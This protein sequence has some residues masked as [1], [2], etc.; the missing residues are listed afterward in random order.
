MKRPPC[1]GG[2]NLVIAGPSRSDAIRQS[3]FAKKMDGRVKP[4]HDWLDHAP[5]NF[6][7]LIASK[8]CTPPPTRFV[9]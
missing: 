7:S 8:S 3:I 5:E 9:V 6:N 1:S 2:L 4:G